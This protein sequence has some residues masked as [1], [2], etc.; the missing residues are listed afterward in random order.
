M[1][2][3]GPLTLWGVRCGRRERD[4]LGVEE[5]PDQFAVDR[6]VGAIGGRGLQTLVRSRVR[7]RAHAVAPD[8][9][10]EE[11][12][13]HGESAKGGSRCYFH[14]GKMAPDPTSGERKKERGG[15]PGGNPRGKYA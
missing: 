5:R 3:V 13:G 10:R 4:V 7:D 14:F 12:R 9:D 8:E 6:L 15:Y 2:T 11:D 1:R